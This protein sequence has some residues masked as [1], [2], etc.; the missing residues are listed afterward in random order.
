MSQDTSESSLGYITG[1]LD[2]HSDES[3]M[4]CLRKRKHCRLTIDK[5]GLLISILVE[6]FEIRS[7]CQ[8]GRGTILQDGMYISL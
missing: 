4:V 5:N 6:V 7:Q 2:I 1:P 8:G 3:V